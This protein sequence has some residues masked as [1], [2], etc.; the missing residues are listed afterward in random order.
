[1][2]ETFKPGAARALFFSTTAFAVSF[3]VWGLISALAPTFTQIYKLSATSKSLL[4]AIPVLLG[5][6]GRLPAG[7]LADR[8]GGRRVFAALLVL[9]ALPAVAV[10]F[11]TSFTQLLWLGL[12]LGLAGSTFPV[13]VGFTSKWF[14]AEKQGT[15]LGVYGMGNIGQSVAVFG[16]PLLVAYAFGGNWR[17]VFFVFAA[18]AL[19]W[20][21]VFYL[22]AR[23]AATNARRKTLSENLSVL[24]REPLAWVL[25]LFYFLTFGGFVALGIYLPTLLK[26]MFGLSPTDAGAR[27]AGFVVLATL[28]RPLG[29]WLADRLGGVRVLVYIFVAIATLGLLM[30]CAWMPTFTVG[31]LGAAAALGLGNG[32][33]FKLVPQFFPKETGTVTGLVGAFGGLGGFFPP[34]ALGL[35]RD[36][37]GGYAWG[38]VF[39]ACF[40]LA[41]LAVHYFVLVRPGGGARPERNG[42]GA[43]QVALR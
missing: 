24:R 31:A 33:V 10:G 34:L 22:C 9:S 27:T 42:V 25:S 6:V 4:I 41:C 30:G 18:L 37:T 7:M 39:L 43:P 1:M 35:I 3:A 13:G 23:D 11:S 36:A 17:P 8:F 14:S 19:V 2:G 38:F 16:A 15:A 5:S 12:F 26:D 29:G 32:A 21:V 20:G 28:M 40:A